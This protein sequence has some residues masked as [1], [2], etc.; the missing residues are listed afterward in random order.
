MDHFQRLEG[1]LH[2]EDVPL[3]DIAAQ[4]GTPAYVYSAATLTRHFTVFDAA[5]AETDHMVCFAVKAC[6]NIAILARLAA[7][8]AGSTSCLWGSFTE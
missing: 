2:C 3:A 1:H 4:V 6:S 8:G 5:W 7:L